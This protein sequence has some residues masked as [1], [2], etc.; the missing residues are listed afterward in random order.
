M[1]SRST[2]ILIPPTGHANDPHASH[3]SVNDTTY[4]T[5]SDCSGHVCRLHSKEA[6]GESPPLEPELLA[7]STSHRTDALQHTYHESFS[8]HDHIFSSHFYLFRISHNHYSLFSHAL[9]STALS[10]TQ[11]S[12]DKHT[13]SSACWAQLHFLPCTR[14]KFSHCRDI[15][16]MSA[17]AS[18]AATFLITHAKKPR[19]NFFS[20]GSVL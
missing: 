3:G 15:R 20:Q 4:T 11:D 5:Q 14:N 2:E 19:E 12:L 17:H 1:V 6:C 9:H 18:M 7:R 13:V 16:Q 10:L 8:M